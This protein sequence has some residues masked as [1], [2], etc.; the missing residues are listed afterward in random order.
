MAVRCSI[1]I[2]CRTMEEKF[3]RELTSSGIKLQ[4]LRM[5]KEWSISVCERIRTETIDLCFIPNGTAV[6]S[7]DEAKETVGE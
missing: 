7:I 6:C 3:L 1:R 4:K 2:E 5:Q